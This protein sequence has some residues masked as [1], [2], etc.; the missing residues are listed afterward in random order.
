MLFATKEG[1]GNRLKQRIFPQSS[2]DSD[3]HPQISGAPEFSCGGLA[4]AAKFAGS[5]LAFLG[6]SVSC[7]GEGVVDDVLATDD[8]AVGEIADAAA[9]HLR[10]PEVRQHR[11][12]VLRGEHFFG[13]CGGKGE[14][15]NC[16][17][18]FGEI[19]CG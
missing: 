19:L 17:R 1:L 3:S 11:S 6:E 7:S 9:Q 18:M 2:S 13:A 10:D 8:R 16:F 12:F 4:V 5:V 15:G 14:F